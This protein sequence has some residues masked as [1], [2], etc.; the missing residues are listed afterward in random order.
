DLRVTADGKYVLSHDADIWRCS[1]GTGTISSMTLDELN[2]YSFSYAKLGTTRIELKA[3]K[4]NKITTFEQLLNWNQSAKM[5]LVVHLKQSLNETQV[6]EVQA[7]IDKYE[8]APYIS[9][10]DSINTAKRFLALNNSYDFVY[11][12]ANEVSSGKVT[13]DA[14]KSGIDGTLALK[15]NGTTNGE[16]YV[17]TTAANYL[18]YRIAEYCRENNIKMLCYSFEIDQVDDLI[19][20][21]VEGFVRNGE[22]PDYLYAQT[23][24]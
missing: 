17:N 9:L 14:I 20:A 19:A 11:S 1:D 13:V 21:G 4:D 5:K 22:I 18:E 10:M 7:L 16:V 15:T 8:Q 3:Y 6:A 12:V 2:I 24:S 23:L